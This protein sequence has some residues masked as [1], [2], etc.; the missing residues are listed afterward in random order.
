MQYFLY[1]KVYK[2]IKRLLRFKIIK[3]K[4]SS[5]DDSLFESVKI[6]GRR[7]QSAGKPTSGFPGQKF[8]SLFMTKMRTLAIF[9]ANSANQF[10]F[11]TPGV[12]YL[13]ASRLIV[14]YLF[15]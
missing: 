15:W 4:R 11:R 3:V 12:R 5:I 13:N 14:K 10:Y 9:W 7:G 1:D 8:Y 2:K 6:V